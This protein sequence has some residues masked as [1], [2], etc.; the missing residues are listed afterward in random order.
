[1]WA[2]VFDAMTYTARLDSD[3]LRDILGLLTELDRTMTV[4]VL[5]LRVPL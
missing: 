4:H 3:V 1:M 2:R 5:N